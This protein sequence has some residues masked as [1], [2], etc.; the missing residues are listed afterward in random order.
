MTQLLGNGR[1][2]GSGVQTI[3]IQIL[4]LP[5][6]GRASSDKLTNLSEPRLPYVQIG[7]NKMHL[8]ELLRLEITYIKHRV[9]VP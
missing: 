8:V 7:E 4:V 3:W 2:L 1:N 5:S 6:A 9:S